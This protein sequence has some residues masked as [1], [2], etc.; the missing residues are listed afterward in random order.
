LWD[1]L[2]YDEKLSDCQKTSFEW[3]Q[4]LTENIKLKYI[5]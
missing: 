1:A 5:A 4:V 3:S 2:N